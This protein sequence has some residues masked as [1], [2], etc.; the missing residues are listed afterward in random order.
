MSD[1]ESTGQ[2]VAG[3][4]TGPA[5]VDSTAEPAA[6]TEAE[7]AAPEDAQQLRQEIEQTREQLG[8]TAKQLAAKADV[9]SRGRD[10][11]AALAGRVTTTKARCSGGP[12]RGGATAAGYTDRCGGWS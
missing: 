8:E 9:K 7:P 6:R 10:Q 12:L 2:P 1:V 5:A 3:P 4:V 11:A